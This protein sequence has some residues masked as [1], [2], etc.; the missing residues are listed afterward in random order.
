MALNGMSIP[1]NN[2]GLVEVVDSRDDLSD[3]SPSLQFVESFTTA[4]T[5]HEISAATHLS[6]QVVAV[7]SLHH[8]HAAS[9]LRLTQE[10]GS[11]FKDGL[12]WVGYIGD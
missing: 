4:D 2:A 11:A 8:L 7:L 12:V 3:V 6:H 9:S 1:V 5:G 10:C